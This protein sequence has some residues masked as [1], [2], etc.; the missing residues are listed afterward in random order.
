[1][2]FELLELISAMAL[3]VIAAQLTMMV[4]QSRRQARFE[5]IQRTYEEIYKNNEQRRLLVKVTSFS[6]GKE[7]DIEMLMHENEE[8]RNDVIEALNYCEYLAM[9][10][11]QGVLDE[12]MVRSSYRGLL[13][14]MHSHFER[15]IKEFRMSSNDPETFR[16]F[17]QLVEMWR[18]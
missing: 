8:Y 6:Q 5:I 13:F 15:L 14:F 18:S 11:Y 7:F 10:I 12:K 2:I 9:G 16:Y 4:Y 1:M 17:S 3:V